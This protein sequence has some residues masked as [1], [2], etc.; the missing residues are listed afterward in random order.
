[1]FWRLYFLISCL[2]I[3][4][5]VWLLC[6]SNAAEFMRQTVVLLY[7]VYAADQ[8]AIS[9]NSCITSQLLFFTTCLHCLTSIAEETLLKGFKTICRTKVTFDGL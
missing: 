9:P 8:T 4:F 7:F 2:F 6:Q 5:A 3:E 1:M